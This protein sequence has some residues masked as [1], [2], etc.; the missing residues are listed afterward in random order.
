MTI[1]VNDKRGAQAVITSTKVPNYKIVVNK[2]GYTVGY[3]EDKVDFRQ[4]FCTKSYAIK[5]AKRTL[6]KFAQYKYFFELRKGVD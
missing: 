4:K 1:I 5:V 2:D 3:H 6:K